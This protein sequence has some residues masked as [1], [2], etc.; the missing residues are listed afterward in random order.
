[1]SSFVRVIECGSFAAAAAAADLSPAMIGKHIRF[2]EAQP[3]E[4]L[5][6]RSSSHLGGTYNPGVLPL[7]VPRFLIQVEG[8]YPAFIRPRSWPRQ[9]HSIGVSQPSDV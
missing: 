5:L 4:P 7:T 6:K 8:E 3:G 2:L 9:Q 1:M